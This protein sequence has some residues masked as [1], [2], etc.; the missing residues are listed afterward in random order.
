MREEPA[1]PDG[2][3]RRAKEYPEKKLRMEKRT[4]IAYRIGLALVAVVMV[5]LP[6]L[7]CALLAAVGWLIYLHAVTN[8]S[9]LGH[10]YSA[11]LYVG[12][13][14]SGIVLIAFMLKPLFAPRG[15]R[16]PACSIS[17]AEAPTLFKLISVISE[18]TGAP[19]PAEVELDC[20]VN[21]SASFS[22]GFSSFWHDNLTLTIGMPLA[23]G[24][25]QRQLAGVI[26][27]ELGHFSQ[28]GARRLTFIVAS[29]NGWFARVVFE[30][31]EW[32]ERLQE[33][34]E[35]V[36]GS[37]ALIIV[38]AKLCVG[39][40][41]MVLWVF[42]ML[43][44]GVSC[45]M[46]RQMEY[47][48]DRCQASIAGSDSF[49]SAF[50]RLMELSATDDFVWGELAE[51]Y[52]R[53]TLPDDLPA[54]IW[55]M[56]GKMPAEVASEVAKRSKGQRT[57]LFSTHPSY[58]ARLRRAKALAAPGLPFTEKPASKLFLDFEGLSR[59]VTALKYSML[60]PMELVLADR[61]AARYL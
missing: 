22:E 55:Q 52:G 19:L 35:T 60:P 38:M 47:D 40:T 27:H 26:A 6:L 45:Y 21:A 16:P 25:T 32:D 17:T 1:P 49:E 30:R 8:V 54:L 28:R 53:K 23:A 11:V 43:A 3:R 59:K 18:K 9:W 48:A 5:L 31:D 14:V 42:M 58:T 41:R 33:A 34:L 4:S 56:H 7:Y 20:E 29:V 39:L 57:G 13:V 50:N 2:M 44:H 51:T 10:R 15:K 24:L 46:S 37:P 12:L 36:H 61:D